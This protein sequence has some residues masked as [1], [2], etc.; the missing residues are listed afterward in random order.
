[1]HEVSLAA[2]PPVLVGGVG[3]DGDDEQPINAIKS[4]RFIA[5]R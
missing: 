2:E 4:R 1:V 5:R 3:F